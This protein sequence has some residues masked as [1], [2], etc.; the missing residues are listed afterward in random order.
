MAFFKKK[1]PFFGKSTLNVT[2]VSLKEGRDETKFLK[3]AIN[4]SDRNSDVETSF[5]NFLVH[6][7]TYDN[8]KSQGLDL[9]ETG[10]LIR[11]DLFKPEGEKVKINDKY[12]DNGKYYLVLLKA[13]L[14]AKKKEKIKKQS[15]VNIDELTDDLPF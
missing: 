9:Y 8:L 1:A 13:T 7:K 11:I 10:N 2:I 12:F 4:P 15:D 14:I 6:K 5:L 3:V